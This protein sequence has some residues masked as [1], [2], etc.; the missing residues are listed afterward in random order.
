MSAPDIEQLALHLQRQLIEHPELRDRRV[1]VNGYGQASSAPDY[2]ALLARYDADEQR[3]H[4]FYVEHADKRDLVS[5]L[6][7]TQRAWRAELRAVARART[8]IVLLEAQI[9]APDAKLARAESKQRTAQA[10]RAVAE[11]QVRALEKRLALAEGQIASASHPTV[12]PG[13]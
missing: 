2:D 9:Y 10:Y 6:I 13:P 8:K 11:E 7:E 5:E 1:G 3:L 12:V 4:A